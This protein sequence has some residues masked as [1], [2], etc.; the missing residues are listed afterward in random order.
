MITIG[1]YEAKTRFSEL[2]RQV[3]K[4]HTVE[5]TRRGKSIARLV[6][7]K[8][9]KTD[10]ASVIEQMKK[11]QREKKITL[12]PGMTVRKMIEEGRR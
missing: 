10:I 3:S 12:G 1:A 8:N 6:P 11:F 4:G 2:L 5:I 9:P 7:S